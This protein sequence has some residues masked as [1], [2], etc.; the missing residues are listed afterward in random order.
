MTQAAPETYRIG[1]IAFHPRVRDLDAAMALRP[2][3]EDFAWRALPDAIARVCERLPL[4][5]RHLRIERLDLDLGRVGDDGLEDD[6]IAAFETALNEALAA[7]LHRATYAPDGTAR[8]LAPRAALAETFG[9]YLTN[10]TAPYRPGAGT[11]DPRVHEVVATVETGDV[12]PSTITAVE[13]RGFS[14]AGRLLRPARVTI[15]VAPHE[16]SA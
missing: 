2:R 14:L 3:L 12:L 5:G 6:G 11:F 16:R 8:L 7:A 9:N 4:D 13:R 15:A 10:G 1:R